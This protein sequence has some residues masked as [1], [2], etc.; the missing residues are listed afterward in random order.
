MT[1]YWFSLKLV[2]PNFSNSPFMSLC[3]WHFRLWVFCELEP[4]LAMYQFGVI[5]AC[6]ILV[7]VVRNKCYIAGPLLNLFGL[8][9]AIYRVNC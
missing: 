2:L 6:C 5:Q 9:C 8:Y 3:L 7:C 1:L 4:K